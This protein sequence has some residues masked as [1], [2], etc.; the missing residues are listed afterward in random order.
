MSDTKT[1]H[2]TP[3]TL[4]NETCPNGRCVK[5]KKTVVERDTLFIGVNFV[6]AKVMRTRCGC[7]KVYATEYQSNYNKRNVDRALKLARPSPFPPGSMISDG[8]A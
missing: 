1:I 3:L 6:P 5:T 7:G 8:G 4:T 2:K